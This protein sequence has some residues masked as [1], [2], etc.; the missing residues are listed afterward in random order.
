MA[1][2]EAHF[3]DATRVVFW[4]LVASTNCWNLDQLHA[5]PDYGGIRGIFG[6]GADFRTRRTGI[7]RDLLVRDVAGIDRKKPPFGRAA[8]DIVRGHSA[9]VPLWI[10]FLRP[11]PFD[12]LG[13][14]E[15]AGLPLAYRA[16]ISARAIGSDAASHA[17]TFAGAPDH[18]RLT[19]PTADRTAIFG[20]HE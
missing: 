10:R 2:V 20:V 9:L 8:H 15:V 11:P 14:I 19:R 4:A 18:S 12:L 3:S 7:F 6:L 17:K 16:G 13:R 1:G 5:G